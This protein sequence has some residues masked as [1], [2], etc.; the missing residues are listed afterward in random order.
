MRMVELLNVLPLSCMEVVDYFDRP[1]DLEHCDPDEFY[2]LSVSSICPSKI[3]Q[4]VKVVVN[5]LNIFG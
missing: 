4:K 2:N 1:Y 5:T 3:R